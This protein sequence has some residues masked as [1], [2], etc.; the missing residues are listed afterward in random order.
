MNKDVPATLKIII[1]E[2]SVGKAS[3]LLRFTDVQNLQQQ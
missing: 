3:L 1:G 2:N